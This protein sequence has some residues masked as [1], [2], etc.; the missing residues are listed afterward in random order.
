MGEL[1]SGLSGASGN[2]WVWR[3]E[4]VGGTRG[5]L[6]RLSGVARRCSRGRGGEGGGLEGGGG[7]G[8]GGGGEDGGRWWWHRGKLMYR[9]LLPYHKNYFS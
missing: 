5:W 7:R 8:H 2:L 4:V 9:Y 6:W 1:A 3:E